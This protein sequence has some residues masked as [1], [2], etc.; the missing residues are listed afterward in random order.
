MTLI[1]KN[2][3]KNFDKFEVVKNL[4]ISILQGEVVAVIGPNGA[5]KS[6]LLDLI[7]GAT[8]PSSGE[9]I[10]SGKLIQGK[11]PYE[12]NR[13]GMARSFQKNNIFLNLTVFDNLCCATLWSLKYKYNF[14]KRLSQLKNVTQRVQEMLQMLNLESKAQVL[15]S[16]LSY[17]EQRAL[18]LGVTLAGNAHLVLLDE[19]TSGMSQHETRHFTGL[20]KKMTQGKT[21]LIVEHDMNVVFELADKIAVMVAGEL[22]AFDVPAA[23]R[24]NSQVQAVYLGA[25]AK[26]EALPHKKSWQSEEKWG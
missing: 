24:A 12:I 26:G 11:N 17:A 3:S 7:S 20:I 15:A 9:I 22:L 2:L 4:N 1:L 6:T 5:G 8:K 16:Q 21:L 23:I 18:E 25:L 14:I 19:P 13:M 10:F